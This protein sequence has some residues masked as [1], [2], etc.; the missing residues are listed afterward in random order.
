[1]S[2]DTEPLDALVRLSHALGD[3]RAGCAILA[4]GNTSAAV[5]S[6]SFYVKASGRSLST[7]TEDGFCRVAAAPILEAM[8][9]AELSDAAVKDL[10]LASVLD[11]EPGVMPSV[12][13]F[14]HAWLLTLPDVR[15]IGH[16]HPT[17]VNALLCS[18]QAAEHASGRLFPDHIVSCGPASCFVDYVDPGI[19]LALAIR[20]A[21]D[22]YIQ[23]W[24]EAPKT[25][26]MRNH[27]LIVLGATA[28]DVRA[29][30]VMCVKAAQVL[31]GT[32]AFGGPHFLGPDQVQRIHGRPD[33][34]YR[35]R[36]IE[37]Q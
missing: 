1:M 17:A 16:T 18:E 13:T 19:P 30:T 35:R 24:S 34:A 26:L 6:A 21:V 37:R 36:Q 5:D 29:G 4:E 33:E 8:A 27:G 11:A 7:I 22:A 15:F 14:F 12:E 25:I 32:M 20:D 31:Q 2:I 3:E 23:V 9:G 10:L 28:T